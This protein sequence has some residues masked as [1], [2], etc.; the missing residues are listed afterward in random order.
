MILNDKIIGKRI[1]NIRVQTPLTQ[2]KLAEI[3]NLS[4]SYISLIE[5]GTRTASLEVLVN[6]ANNLGVTVDTFLSGHQRHDAITYETD[7][8]ALIEDCDCYE[9]QVIYDAA[10][11]TKKS[12]RENKHLYYMSKS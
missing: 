12:L 9:R 7:F 11:A 5:S 6:L 4:A 10:S 1:K 3:C 2:E 8:A